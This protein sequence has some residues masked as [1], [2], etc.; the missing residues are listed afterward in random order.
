M[1]A[2]TLQTKVAKMPPQMIQMN[3]LFGLKTLIFP[4]MTLN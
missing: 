4:Q 3:D 1:K 2:P